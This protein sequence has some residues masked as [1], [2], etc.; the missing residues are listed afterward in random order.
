MESWQKILVTTF[1]IYALVGFIKGLVESKNK[2]NAFGRCSI[3]SFLGAFVWGDAVVFGIF[4]IIV[5]IFILLIKDWIL[6]WL[7][8]TIFWS[9]RSL[10]ETIYWFNQQFSVIK[11]N[12][13][14]VFWFYKIFRNDSVWFVWQIYWQ[15]LAVVSIIASIYL[16]KLWLG[17]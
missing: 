11:R 8:Y 5:A 14:S 7:I 13:P 4:W 2:T 10:G 6:F 15:C 9:V 1:G 16:T 17:R 12:P 3:F